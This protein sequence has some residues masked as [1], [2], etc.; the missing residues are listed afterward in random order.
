[1]NSLFG[2]FLNKYEDSDYT[3][4]QKVKV[5]V[6]MAGVIFLLLG[7][8]VNVYLFKMGRDILNV[9]V[10]SI[11]T[12]QVMVAV[13]LF[14]VRAGK[15]RAASHLLVVIMM[16]GIWASFFSTTAQ[17]DAVTKMNSIDYLYPIIILATI[18]TRKRWVLIY[19]ALNSVLIV[20]VGQFFL[21]R[22]SLTGEQMV[23]FTA[24][25]L[26]TYILSGACCY[27]FASISDTA[28][29]RI[30]QTL[31]ENRSFS[32]NIRNILEET[33]EVASKLAASTEQ[34]AGAVDSFS[35]N[36]QTQASSVEEI[37]STVE[38]VAASGESM[39]HMAE[40]QV[41]LTQ[42][43]RD[44]ME[45]LYSIVSKA[46]ENMQR[47]MVIRDDLNHMVEKSRLEIQDTLKVMSS[48]ASRFKNVEETVKIIED[49]SEQIN[50]L[51]LNAAIEAARA[52]EHGR[53]FAVVADE[54]G[55][56][57]DNTSTN[58]KSINDLFA[59][60][61]TEINKA[62]KTMEIFI[63]SLNRMIGHISDFSNMVDGV[64][65]ITRQDLEQ[66]KQARISLGGVIDEA[67]NIL[68]AIN[69][70]KQAFE[71]VSKSL[72]VIN[73]TAQEIASGSEELTGT[74][75]EIAQSAQN[76]MALSQS[77]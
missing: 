33:T 18:L 27:A 3:E 34:M 11:L 39:Y 35:D 68:V 17:K 58:V 24:D 36:A 14:L 40:K 20:A 52:G 77:S 8:L 21:A 50:L 26:I 19:T 32:S 65:E 76:L 23:D 54:I 6:I 12:I 63:D 5:I 56:L 49:I 53:G 43:V 30:R 61:N 42:K 7:V 13:S 72:T 38:E 31:D 75:K 62:Y 29:L 71:E 2:Y 9:S 57:A 37:T 22:G 59:S 1:M 16:A 45:A 41:Q 74:S 67:N 60:S 70:Q 47:G 51:S 48:A 66:N 64:R 44:E 69:E 10:L 55:K 73:N 15:S 46:V 28:N 4:Q 25:G